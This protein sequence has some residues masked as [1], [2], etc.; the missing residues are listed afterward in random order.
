[1]PGPPRESPLMH[2]LFLSMRQFKLVSIKASNTN[3]A[4]LPYEENHDNP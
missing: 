2:T 3:D 1:M 4:I